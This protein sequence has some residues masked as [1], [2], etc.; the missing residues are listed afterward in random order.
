MACL[1][2]RLWDLALQTH[3]ATRRQTKAHTHTQ[4]H[5]RR[6]TPTVELYCRFAQHSPNPLKPHSEYFLGRDVTLNRNVG[7]ALLG[8]VALKSVWRNYSGPPD[9]LRGPL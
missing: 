3:T 1:G 6:H 2:L 5:A 8:G 7:P 9:C 4:R